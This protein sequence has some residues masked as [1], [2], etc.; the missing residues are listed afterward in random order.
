MGNEFTTAEAEAFIEALQNFIT[1]SHRLEATGH[2][3][4]RPE[5]TRLHAAEWIATLQEK[6]EVDPGAGKGKM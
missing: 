2:K 6:R 1:A 3:T 5:L 4:D